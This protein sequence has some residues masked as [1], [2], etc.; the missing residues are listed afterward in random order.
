[1]NNTIKRTISGAFFLLIMVSS[2][3]INKFVF[4]TLMM[5]IMVGMMKEFYSMTMGEDFKFSRYLAVLTGVIVF[6]ALFLMNAYGTTS[7]VIAIA[8]VPLLVLMSSSLSSKNKEKFWKFSHMYT[9]ILYIAVPM[10]CSNMLAF[11]RTHEFDGLPMLCFFIIIWASD[12]GAFSFGI[13]LGQ[14]YGKKLCPSISPKKS[15]I[16]FWGGLL[17]AVITA[18]LL[19]LIGWLSMPLVH[20]AM[21]ATVMHIAG[22]FGDMFESQWKRTYDLKDSGSII[23]GHGGLLDRFDSSLMAIPAGELYL[24]LVSLL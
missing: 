20:C 8:I 24:M 3:L 23:P 22:V 17:C 10:A 18:V 13:T 1:M 4:G 6:I 12:V 9:G 21:L 16:G 14:K 7:K 11:T 5:L 19:K 2:L 15:W